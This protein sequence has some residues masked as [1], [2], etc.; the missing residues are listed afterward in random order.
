MKPRYYHRALAVDLWND[1]AVSVINRVQM[2]LFALG[3]LAYAS[4]A[5]TKDETWIYVMAVLVLSALSM[6]FVRIVVSTATLAYFFFLIR[7]GDRE[8]ALARDL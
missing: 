8:E 6:F 5:W 1:K 4:F 2:T 3:M 7:R